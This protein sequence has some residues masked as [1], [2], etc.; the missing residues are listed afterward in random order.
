MGEFLGLFKRKDEQMVQEKC[1][2]E[3]MNS[4]SIGKGALQEE[5]VRFEILLL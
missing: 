5:H 4:C 2:H 1:P 3:V